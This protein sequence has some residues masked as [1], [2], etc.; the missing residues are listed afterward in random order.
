MFLFEVFFPAIVSG[1]EVAGISLILK[2]V[3]HVKLMA[4]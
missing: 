2:Y 3:G 1:S 4:I